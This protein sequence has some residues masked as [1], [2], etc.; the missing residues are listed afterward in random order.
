MARGGVNQRPFLRHPTRAS[1]GSVEEL[2]EKSGEKKAIDG[3]ITL[4]LDNINIVP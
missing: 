4:S 3:L 1:P 2:Q